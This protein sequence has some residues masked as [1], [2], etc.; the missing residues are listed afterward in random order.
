[1]EVLRRLHEELN[2]RLRATIVPTRSQRELRQALRELQASIERFN[3]RWHELLSKLDLT[4]VNK[5]REGYNR[6]YV[7]EKDG[8][9]RSPAVARQG[10]KRLPPLTLADVTAVVP[11]LPVPRLATE[12]GG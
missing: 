11:P 3:R 1:L 10:F 8:A 5:L 7:L 9:I 4:A 2:P 12:N 6:Y